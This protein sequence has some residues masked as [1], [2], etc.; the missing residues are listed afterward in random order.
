MLILAKKNIKRIWFFV[1]KKK[2]LKIE[3]IQIVGL[4][5]KI[6]YNLLDIKI[7]KMVNK[8]QNEEENSF[9]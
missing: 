2:N 3:I 9:K 1:I 7:Y 6:C 4:K 8:F 5:K